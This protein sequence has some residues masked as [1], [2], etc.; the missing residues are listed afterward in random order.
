M[1]EKTVQWVGIKFC[2]KLDKTYSETF[3]MP[4]DYGYDAIISAIEF[5]SYHYFKEGRT[6][7]EFGEYLGRQQKY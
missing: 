3:E 7:V 6:L 1:A 4:K 5:D 2:L